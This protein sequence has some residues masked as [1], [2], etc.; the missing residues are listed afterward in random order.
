MQYR[1]FCGEKFKNGVLFKNHREK[2]EMTIQMKLHNLCL[3]V[4]SLSHKCD[5]IKKDIIA[6][7]QKISRDNIE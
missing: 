6:L 2:C 5:K 7:H 3:Y 4:H 1:C